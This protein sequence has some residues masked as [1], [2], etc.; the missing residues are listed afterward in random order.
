MRMLLVWQLL[1]S[2]ALMVADIAALSGHL[3]TRT[4]AGNVMELPL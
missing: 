3:L 4:V 2:P 1:Q